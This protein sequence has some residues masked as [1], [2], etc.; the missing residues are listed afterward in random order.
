MLASAAADAASRPRLSY[1]AYMYSVAFSEHGDYAK[2]EDSNDGTT[3]MQRHQRA[4]FDVRIKASEPIA[5]ASTRIDTRLIDA[6]GPL[7]FS[8]PFRDVH[9]NGRLSDNG[10]D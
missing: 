6:T 4:S 2:D 10:F 8:V 5:V 1:A 9:V 7:E 3:D